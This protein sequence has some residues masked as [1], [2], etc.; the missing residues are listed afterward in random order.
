MHH[1]NKEWFDSI[2]FIL[3]VSDDELHVQETQTE[4]LV[5]ENASPS[6][7]LCETKQVGF[8][9]ETAKFFC[10]LPGKP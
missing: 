2:L 10:L 4:V 8:S 9:A 6:C 1:A 3:P 7:K 5:P